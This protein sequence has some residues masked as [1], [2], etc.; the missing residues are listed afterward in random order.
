MER[1][2]A[3][4]PLRPRAVVLSAGRSVRIPDSWC[5]GWVSRVRALYSLRVIWR[6]WLPSGMCCAGPRAVRSAGDL[7]RV[8]VGFHSG[9]TGP[10]FY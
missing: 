5:R 4:E 2:A 3:G 1:G 7:A 6:R 8:G 10:H 9:P